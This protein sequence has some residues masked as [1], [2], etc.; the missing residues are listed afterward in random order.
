MPT[1]HKT[2]APLDYIY[3]EAIKPTPN[4]A[5]PLFWRNNKHVTIVNINVNTTISL[6]FLY[7]WQIPQISDGYDVP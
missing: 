7:H 5:I 1:L 6:S 4:K 2:V 3:V